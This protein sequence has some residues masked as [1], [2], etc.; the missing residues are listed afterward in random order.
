MKV[1]YAG[2]VL[3]EGKTETV[4]PF[5]AHQLLRRI[6]DCNVAGLDYKPKFSWVETEFD[7]AVLSSDVNHLDLLRRLQRVLV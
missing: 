3:I 6:N 5:V 7:E 4:S 2:T 1:P